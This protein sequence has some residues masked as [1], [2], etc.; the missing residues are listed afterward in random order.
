MRVPACVS[1]QRH[2]DDPETAAADRD[3]DVDQID[4]GRVGR[5]GEPGRNRKQGENADEDGGA[6]AVVASARSL[7]VDTASATSEWQRDNLS[8]SRHVV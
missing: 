5:Q 3:R 1:V 2:R 6:G 4:R 8:S 7:L